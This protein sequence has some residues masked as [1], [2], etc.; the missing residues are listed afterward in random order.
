MLD[1]SGAGMA[2]PLSAAQRE[3]WLAEQR[4]D[5]ANRVYR[6]GEY[7]EICGPIDPAL[8]EAALRRVVGEVDALQVRFIENGDGPRQVVEPSDWSMPVI[9]VSQA[10]DA[11]SAAEAW[12]AADAAQPMPLSRGPLFR[13]A[14]FRLS[15][16]LFLWYQSYHL[17]VMDAFGYS[18]VA[19]RVAEMYTALARGR[20]PDENNVFGSLRQLLDSD[21]AYRASEQFEQDRTFWIERLADRPEP[22]RLA[23]RSSGASPNLVHRTACLSP[24]RMD[25]LRALASRAGVRWSRV[26]IAATA[27]YVHRLTD[28]QDVIVGLPV[29]TRQD[30]VLKLVPGPVSN[31]L[32]L[33]LSVRPDMSLS[34]LIEHVDAQIREVLAHQRYRGEDLRR[35]LRLPSTTGALGHPIIN[36]MSFA[37][38]LRFAGSPTVVHNVSSSLIADLT[39]RVWDRRDGSGLQILL[40]SHP[41]ACSANELAVHHQRF[42]RLLEAIA[43]A[44]PHQTVGRIDLLAAEECPGLPTTLPDPAAP[45]VEQ[46]YPPV[47]DMID[48]WVRRS[49]QAIALEQGDH[50]CSYARLGAWADGIL[51]G[52]AARGLG[53][54]DVVAVYGAPSP[55]LV[56]AMVAVVSGPGVL[57]TLDPRL[58]PSRLQVMMNESRARFLIVAGDTPGTP[59]PVALDGLRVLRVDSAHTTVTEPPESTR[60]RGQVAPAPIGPGD[61]AYVVFTSGT[62]GVP[63]GVV[64]RH[65]GLSHFLAWQRDSFGIKPGDRC[66][67]LTGLSFDVVLRDVFLPLVSGAT[68]CLPASDDQAAVRVIGWLA[69]AGITCAHVVP[70]LAQAWLD[71]ADTEAP[72][73]LRH[74]F[75]AG[76]PL[77][78]RLVAR[79]RQACPNT[80]IV[81]LYGPTETTLA[82]CWYRVPADSPT[83]VQPVGS[84]MPGTQAL[85]VGPGGRRC[86]IGEV[87]EVVVRSPYR[88][89]GYLNPPAGSHPTFVPNPHT[90]DPADL[91]Y[92]TGDRGRYRP[93]G[94][95]ELLGR[96]DRQVKI[97]GVRVEPDEVAAV[98]ATHPAVS[99]AVVATHTDDGGKPALVAYLTTSGPTT[100]TAP[101][102]RSYLAQRLPAVM[103]PGAFVLLDRMPATANGK[104][105]WQALPPALSDDTTAP[106]P[107][108]ARSPVEEALS[109]I[110]A[111]VL[112]VD[113][114]GVHDDFFELGGH[115][116]L[117]MQ[118]ASRVRSLLGAEL[119]IRL[120]FEAPT[121]AGLAQRLVGGGQARL[122]LEA[123]E[124][125]DALPLSSGQRRL[126][127]LEQMEGMGAA[128]HIPVAVRLSG[129]LNREALREAVEDVVARHESLR[130]VFPQTDGRPWQH[131]LDAGAGGLVWEMGEVTGAGL[132]REMA[133]V[134]G[135]RFDLAVE[136]PLRARLLV[137]SP[138]EHVL[139]LVV[140]HI[141]ADGWS[142]GVLRRDLGVAYAARCRG[143]EPGWARL[144]VQYAD[145]TMW[146]QRLLGDEADPGSV[147][148]AQL[149]YWKAALADLPETLELPCDRPRPAAAT[150]RGE[151]VA[152][153]IGPDLHGGLVELA[154]GNRV[155]LF[156]VLQAGLAALLTRLGAGTDIPIGSPIAGRT[157]DALDD[158]V[159]FFVNTLILRTDTSG[160]PSFAELLERVRETDL[161]AY[162]HQ[163][164]PFEYLVEV[165]NPPR[166]MSRHPLFQVMLVLQNTPQAGSPV[167]L[168][169]V[170][171]SWE[172]VDQATARFDL[173]VSLSERRGSDGSPGGVDGVVEFSTDLFDR[174]SVESMLARLVRLWEAVVAD[175]Y[176]PI[177][178]IEILSPHERRQLL[179]DYNDTAQDFPPETLPGL[180]ETQ[181]RRSPANTAL[182]FE[183]TTLT[184]AQLNARANRLARL[185]IDRGVGPEVFV[186]LAVGPSVEMVV[187]VLAVLK[188]GGAY[189][190]IDSGYPAARIGFML[191]D[192][193]PACLITTSTSLPE[194]NGVPLIVLDHDTTCQNLARYPD[195][196]LRDTDRIRPLSPEHPAY[197][198]YTSGSTGTPK[199]VLV[200]HRSVANLFHSHRER[201]FAPPVMRV[202]G[203]RLRVAQT[204]SLSFDLSWGQLLGMF[205]G[206]ELHVLDDEAR[207]DPHAL[208]AYVTQQHIDCVNATPSYVELLVSRGLLGD[209]GGPVAVFVGGEAVSQQL[210]DQLRSMGGVEAFNFYGP[211]E[212]TVDSLIARLDNSPRPAI[213]RPIANTQVY[214]LDNNLQLVPAGVVGDLY[215]AGAGLARGYLNRPG[216]TSGRF[217][218]CPFG[219]PGTRMYRTGDLVRWNTDGELVFV[220]RVDEQVKVR[221]FRIELGEV[222]AVLAR[223]P[224]VDHVAVVVREDRPGQKC[225][226]AYVVPA[227]GRQVLPSALREH[228]AQSLPDYMVPAFVAELDSLPLTANGKLDRKAL[229]LPEVRVTD[230]RREPR[231]PQ[232]QILCELFAQLLGLAA[233][234]VDDNFFE[235]G[236]DSLLGMQM[237]SRARSVL[238]VKLTIR[239]LFEA[240]TVAGLAHRLHVQRP[241][242]ALGVLLPLRPSGTEIPLF[243][244][245]P[246]MGL[247][248]CYSRLVSLLSEEQPI[249]G[250]QARGIGRAEPLPRTVEE[251]ALDYLDQMRT[252]Q[253]NGPYHLLGWSFGGHVAHAIA[254]ALQDQGQ[255]TA[256]LAILDAYPAGFD[257]SDVSS[258]PRHEFFQSLGNEL[259][260]PEGDEALVLD[261]LRRGSGP[262][263]WNILPAHLGGD[264]EEVFDRVLIA[265]INAA[266]VA[267]KFRPGRFDGSLLFFSAKGN[268]PGVL[269]TPQGWAPYVNGA[270]EHH[271]I[272]CRH[273]EMLQGMPL[274]EIGGVLAA[275]LKMLEATAAQL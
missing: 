260:F 104:I 258:D 202:E 38:H 32:P 124:R 174:E 78:G 13:Y 91:L 36:I 118:V 74:T 65:N 217:V 250:L 43:V 92:H 218:A 170:V 236:G 256:L 4:L 137:V 116:L 11:R 103:M 108:P 7:I 225:L 179:L 143:D 73:A 24:S 19:R 110:C 138:D 228:V 196:D 235:L 10:S 98:L 272:D 90:S 128:Y 48:A 166:S 257:H 155:S 119:S 79:W 58:P 47:A 186:A 93:D 210:W 106:P 72:T 268:I 154:A 251:M 112:G 53:S 107:T 249:Y 214:V 113:H 220:G 253:P 222:E 102:L 255:P 49:P 239:A 231:T 15:P 122:A 226:V 77:T 190:P 139:V 159:G 193:H 132:A 189:L 96:L 167:D 242:D 71:H 169:G 61:P 270:I 59:P 181:V 245:H 30:P 125:P 111:Q 153:R 160:N 60:G 164:L 266:R 232:E 105:D 26:V 89:L 31:L 80:G 269:R 25:A 46:V 21:A 145:Y 271:S 69:Q 156:M 136:P 50:V 212:C 95:L 175:P 221:G 34:E 114:V 195:T 81:N 208:V 163:D 265:A 29:T 205:S 12:M 146:Q 117:A 101:Q 3:I 216:L 42:V 246:M 66:A 148:S 248:W 141:A 55:G 201:V 237:V 180:F 40:Q 224:D 274:R 2:L 144:P 177:G 259:G 254:T 203:R 68:L 135:R 52:L 131:I 56:A 198:I 165:L 213:G 67:Q 75:F 27:V 94:P 70:T 200:E 188:A 161:A 247:S 44:G 199:A 51:A 168:P 147:I 20:E 62:T 8:F 63:K 240:P 157:D 229:P 185:L 123:C 17:I 99:Q 142:M 54:G 6:I 109:A 82:T 151:R 261:V 223:H 133:E 127:F 87:G 215:I 130:T 234:G 41:E 97:R 262:P 267:R 149:T 152:L 172:R 206:H 197:L 184:Y 219:P 85:V 121:V 115:S 192:A 64:G 238:G 88:S 227:A 263:P 176:Q 162:A 191:D 171:T 37:Y 1:L 18:L 16:D 100:P 211:T 134:A 244:I 209:A 140:H 83:G 182:V 5:S 173:S 273:G 9:D 158:L 264:A 84:A 183:Y 35:D 207:S 57:L 243:C 45:L 233:V 204:T 252:V 120:V 86:G 22:V 126:W 275:T 129:R 39:F 178:R 187:A 194:I 33:R 76:E 14:L 23:G 150:H 241:G 28:I 230:R